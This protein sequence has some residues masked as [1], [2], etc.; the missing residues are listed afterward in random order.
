MYKKYNQWY[1]YKLIKQSYFNKPILQ[2][3]QLIN[4]DQQ[5]IHT[6]NISII[7]YIPPNQKFS[8]Q[9]LAFC[10]KV[11]TINDILFLFTQLFINIRYNELISM[12]YKLDNTQLLIILQNIINK[13]QRYLA[14]GKSARYKFKMS[15]F[16]IIWGYLEN[17]KQEE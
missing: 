17:I 8:Q 6:L 9:E 4:E 2:V 1:N 5:Y 3:K 15:I 7:N 14:A 13:K 11:S 16:K 10:N 12:L